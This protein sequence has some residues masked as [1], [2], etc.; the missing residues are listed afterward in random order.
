MSDLAA[1]VSRILVEGGLFAMYSGQFYLPEVMR[2]VGEHLTYRWT[3]AAV[4]RGDGNVIHP[5]GIT[6][7]WKPLLIYSKGPWEKTGRYSDVFWMN[8]KEKTHH[9]W[10]Q[11]LGDVE[12]LVEYFSTPGDLVIDPCGGAFTTAIACYHLGRKFIGC[13]CDESCVIQ[14][15]QRLA[16]EQARRK[17]LEDLKCW[18][19]D[20]EDLMIYHR[21]HDPNERRNRQRDVR[22]MWK[23]HTGLDGKEMDKY[24]N[25]LPAEHQLMW[26]SLAG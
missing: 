16:E 13:D 4:W 7:Q 14:G 11:P 18:I 8:T 2:R 25:M 9:D 3:C 23:N 17:L 26:K 12:K 15:Q 1:L 6:S 10:Q 20:F 5:L 21:K 19:E 24:L 22:G